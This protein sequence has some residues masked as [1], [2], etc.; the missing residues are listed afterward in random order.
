MKSIVKYNKDTKNLECD[1]E[2]NIPNFCSCYICDSTKKC[3]N[4]YR[5]LMLEK[6]EGLQI[7]PYGFYTYY[8]RNTVYTCIIIE[9]EL[10][11]VKRN[12]ESKGQK[13]NSFNKYKKQQFLDI[14]T[15]I[16]NVE[17]MNIILSDCIHDLGNI[18]G[19]FNALTDTIKY[20]YSNLVESDDNI[21]ALIFL[22][23]MI[24]YRLDVIEGIKNQN[25]QRILQK[26]HPQ[27]RKLAILMRY[28]AKNKNV[29]LDYERIQEN[30]VYM[31]RNIYLAM[32]LLMENAV[33]HALFDSTIYIDF[34]ENENYTE[35]II[36]NNARRIEKEEI[37][38]LTQRGCRGINTISKG[39]G[40][41]LTL[42]KAILDDYGAEFKIDVV[43]IN[44]AE[45]IFKVSFKLYTYKKHRID[46]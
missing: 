9:E 41:G 43:Y 34:K 5:N 19:Y 33:K 13:L 46:K 11:K 32:F 17:N 23:D 40:L 31:S 15:D 22:Y 35:V 25:N 1:N 29:K 20:D 8:I 37:P 21:K 36:S 6:K 44:K 7:C 10:T 24:N 39:S 18:G 4:F 16:E 30:Q 45:C 42:A 14:I 2:Q 26:V 28:Q 38:K 3:Q 27:I 12:I